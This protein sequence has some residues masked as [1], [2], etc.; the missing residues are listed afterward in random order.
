MKR[1]TITALL[2]IFTLV[3]TMMP[4]SVFAYADGKV[5]VK[6]ENGEKKSEVVNNGVDADDNYDSAVDV[7][8][9]TGGTAKV[10]VNGNVS[11]VNNGVNAETYQ[12]DSADI[13]VNGD[14]SAGETGVNAETDYDGST[15]ITVNGN[16][17]AGEVGVNA[18]AQTF[19]TSESGKPTTN[20]TVNGN[21]SVGKESEKSSV[22][23]HS[24]NEGASATVTVKGNVSTNSQVI[25]AI[26][27]AVSWAQNGNAS[28]I[29]GG[30]IKGAGGSE[31]TG[32]SAIRY[33]GDVLVRANSVSGVADG[34]HVDAVQFMGKEP[35]GAAMVEIEK[36]ITAS[37][38]GLVLRNSGENHIDVLVKDTIYGGNSG[39]AV[40]NTDSD[41]IKS[42]DVT[43]WKIATG[44]NGK[45]I[46]ENYSPYP[47]PGN[48]DAPVPLDGDDMIP[49]PGGDDFLPVPGKPG[50]TKEEIKKQIHYIIKLEQ[51]KA[52]A[53]LSAV[54]GDGS[55]LRDMHGFGTALEGDKVI[56][57]VDLDPGYKI[58]AAY[59]GNGEKQELLQDANGNYYVVVPEGGG[60]YLSVELGR[61]SHSISYDLGGGT[62][63]GKIGT[64]TKVYDYGTMIKLLGK[65]K[66]DGYRFLYWKGSKY[67]AGADYTVEG[68]HTFTAVWE[69][70]TN[71]DKPASNDS[72]DT[73]YA[74]SASGPK[75]GDSS[76]LF[77]WIRVF[78]AAAAALIC[79][80]MR[81]RACYN[82]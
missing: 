3:F 28:V 14:I 23:A 17:D 27:S 51:P 60:V 74:A 62:Y 19:E 48:G 80:L 55:A 75:T 11:A 76:E 67:D 20:V 39:V 30:D 21:V 81:K 37:D 71:G 42:V 26:V 73:G 41:S 52:G 35:Q 57:R 70:I 43:V 9:K 61:T 68:D 40:Y 79:L 58:N 78:I 31:S 34:C 25:E 22:S 24:Q 45:I 59:N 7:S 15:D 82:H 4:A 6:A 65:P 44:E 50:A 2:L 16:I 1:K 77:I 12:G 72:D 56:L 8:A 38:T 66:R 54:N 18:E 49:L 64:I 29:I 46:N 32:I 5:E 36:G 47:D 13:T 10:T 69:K 63:N 53:R 33:F